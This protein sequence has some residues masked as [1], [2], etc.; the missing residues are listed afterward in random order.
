MG[1]PSSGTGKGGGGSYKYVPQAGFTSRTSD[2]PRTGADPVDPQPG[3]QTLLSKHKFHPSLPSPGPFPLTSSYHTNSEHPPLRYLTFSRPSPGGEFTDYTARYGALQEEDRS[4]LLDSYRGMTSNPTPGEIQSVAKKLNLEALVDVPLIG[5]SS[6]QTRRSR[7]GAALLTRARMIL[8]EDPFAGLDVTSRG[9]IADLLGAVNDAGESGSGSDSE[10][11]RMRTVL[12]LRGTG[13]VG[14]PRWIN[15][16]AQVTGN[17]VWVGSREEYVDR[18]EKGTNKVY[19]SVSV[20][21][22]GPGSRGRAREEVGVGKEPL[23]CMKDV[24]VA[25]GSKKA[26]LYFSPR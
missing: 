26:S 2:R 20:D 21:G 4:T 3:H 7:L 22:A 6:G 25:Y 16:V 23:I 9:E 15:K 14:M 19:R 10:Q 24:N 1:W 12:I 11:M 17:E 8:L 5:L 13:L 18:A